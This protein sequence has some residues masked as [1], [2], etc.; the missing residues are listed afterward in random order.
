MN[1]LHQGA[2]YRAAALLLRG[3]SE[4][5]WLPEAKS[6][7]AGQVDTLFYWILGI[8]VFFFLLIVGLVVF[9]LVKYRRRGEE[10]AVQPSAHHSTALEL[11]WSGI[12]LVIVLAIFVG[13]FKGF[14]NLR[15]APDDA[16]EVQVTA[17]R[18]N[19]S[20]TYPNGHVDPELHVPAGV[21]IRLVMSSLDVIHSF[22]VPDYRVKQDLVPGR[23]T[24]AWFEAKEP[25]ESRIYCAEYCGTS[26]SEM[27]SRV[28]VHAPA[29]FERWL[30][31]AADWMVGL[32]PADAGAE[33]YRR[34]GC[35]QCHSVD[36]SAG[37][38]PT[39][40]SSFGSPRK[41]TDGSDGRVDENYIR[42][43]LLQPAAAVVVGFD[44]VMPTF[45]GRLDD[46]EI[47]ALIAYIKSLN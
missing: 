47:A 39:L 30:Q 7:V 6:T 34:K 12:P 14:L 1:P 24:T 3:D 19:W 21:P 16:Y 4:S 36:G 45:Q 5:F 33:L 25:G 11:A 18:W 40:K 10:I 17:Q 38:G 9:F 29:E 27:L 35:V 37:I 31:E 23:Y 13:G 2:P 20:F 41:F 46:E 15:T 22:Y 8:S 32:S 42:Q 44:P 26:H 43:S 28:V